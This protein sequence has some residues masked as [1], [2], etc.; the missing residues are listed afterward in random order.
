MYILHAVN[1][2]NNEY[3]VHSLYNVLT[4]LIVHRL[5]KLSIVYTVYTAFTKLAVHTAYCEYCKL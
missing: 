2:V 5:L 4:P 3:T 1:I